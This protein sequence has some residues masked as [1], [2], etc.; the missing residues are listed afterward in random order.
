MVEVDD[1]LP[2]LNPGGNLYKYLEEITH[3]VRYSCITQKLG[4]HELV[5]TKTKDFFLE[6]IETMLD[7][8]GPIWMTTSIGRKIDGNKRLY[9]S[10]NIK[11]A[12]VQGPVINDVF[13]RDDGS[14]DSILHVMD[15]ETD[16]GEGGWMVD[17][18]R[19]MTEVEINQFEEDWTSMWIEVEESEDEIF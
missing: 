8:G 10:K 6:D 4:N 1:L 13:I 11:I 9:V 3:V 18:N 7:Y 17:E 14:G 19:E 15:P 5:L 16:Y 2:R 12:E